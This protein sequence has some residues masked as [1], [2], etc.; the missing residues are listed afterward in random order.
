MR[1]SRP[2]KPEAQQPHELLAENW[3]LLLTTY[4]VI[5][6]AA[7]LLAV[8][9]HLLRYAFVTVAFCAAHALVV[10]PAGPQCLSKTT[11]KLLAIGALIFA[12]F[13]MNWGSVHISYGFAHFLMVVQLIK[14]Y[15]PHRSRDLRLIQ[16][17]A[18]FQVLVAG[19]WALSL[20]YLPVFMLTVLALMANFI[21]L[22]MQPEPTPTP[23]V[24]SFRG[25]R[26]APWLDLLSALRLPAAAV[27]VC[28]VLLFIMLP[29]VEALSRTVV[30]TITQVTGF[31]ENVSLHEV[32]QLRESD[33]VVLRVQFL[34]EDQADWPHVAPPHLL[35]RGLSLP[36]YH[37]GQ[38]FGYDMAMR[39]ALAN[40]YS[41]DTPTFAEFTE[42]TVY[43]LQ[44]VDARQRLIRQKVSVESRPSRRLFALYRPLQVEGPRSSESVI[45]HLSD[46][47]IYRGGLRRGDS[48]E[49][50]S[51]VPQFTAEQLEKAGTP[52]PAGPWS[53]FWYVPA[54]IAD[55]LQEAASD[56]E[57]IYAPA[58]DYERVIA[59]RNYLLDTNRFTYT[60]ELPEFGAQEPIE[61][62]LTQTRRGSCEQF[63]T[64]FALI[65]RVLEIP[66]RLVVGYKGGE[67]DA[68]TQIYTFRDLHAHAWVE[69]YFKGLGWLQFDPT[70]GGD[71]PTETATGLWASTGRF[72]NRIQRVAMHAYLRA[73]LRWGTRVI[74][75][76]R[77]RQQRVF[78]Y[79]GSRI[80]A[81]AE[82]TGSFLRSVWPGMP[83]L[84]W[85]Q[86]AVVL[87]LF[88]FAGAVLWVLTA[89]LLRSIQ[90][91]RPGARSD[92]TLR[93]YEELLSLL[94][95][96]GLRR[97]AHATPREFAR[98]AAVQLQA[99]DKGHSEMLNAISLV[100]DLYCRVRFG[101]Y[102]LTEPQRG[103]IREAL[104][105]LSRAARR[106]AAG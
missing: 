18:I 9:E 52:R 53:F 4:A 51:A 24:R 64:A 86:T 49:V 94:R 20:V 36:L 5:V 43:W 41:E 92:R 105:A 55:A 69:V 56:I 46:H 81:V 83:S 7:L 6:S 38:W 29:R 76:N 89:W 100:T 10:G 42:R 66:T 57:R 58:S 91:H 80:L 45:A 17:T 35:M 1:Y 90:W 82:G 14:L 40:G 28:T 93:F 104:Q 101:G 68:A 73:S 54:E 74:G 8:A 11:S 79:L 88:V 106:T 39:Q 96:K 23:G 33:T 27:A 13:Q 61:A 25:S 59:A 63:S 21:A 72:L 26:N 87:L 31:S 37:D 3:P 44:D 62:F 78:E 70:P 32:G 65:L 103:Q 16:V 48:Y 84:G 60:L 95:K 75:Y 102:E 77:T 30:P 98:S 22:E 34:A 2:E 19:L 71:A 67:L 12:L 15:G 47:V 85:T 99:A 50:V 97:P